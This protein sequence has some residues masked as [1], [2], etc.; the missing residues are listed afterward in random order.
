[1]HRARR[2]FRV[3]AP[4]KSTGS[5]DVSPQGRSSHHARSAASF[6]VRASASSPRAHTWKDVVFCGSRT[7][8]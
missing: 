5:R 4:G 8:S 3:G 2:P 1:M 7:S 6:S